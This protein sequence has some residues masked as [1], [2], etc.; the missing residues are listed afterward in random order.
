LIA[1]VTFQ[2]SHNCAILMNL[3]GPTT[4]V[5]CQVNEQRFQHLFA[6]LLPQVLHIFTSM[7]Q[8]LTYRLHSNLSGYPL[9]F[10]R[11][12]YPNK[13]KYKLDAIGWETVKGT[14]LWGDQ[15][16]YPSL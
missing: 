7:P 10:V 15:F 12:S 1:Q 6:H 16:I 9:A 14:K 4:K 11:Q 2:Y 13:P 5:F 3:Y 8:Y